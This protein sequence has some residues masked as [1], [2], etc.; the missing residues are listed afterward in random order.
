MLEE[1]SVRSTVLCTHSLVPRTEQ[2]TAKDPKL[3]RK[4]PKNVRIF[5]VVGMVSAVPRLGPRQPK[6]VGWC[7]GALA[8]APLC[9]EVELGSI[10][11][12]QKKDANIGLGPAVKIYSLWT[13]AR[14]RGC[15]GTPAPAVGWT[16][17]TPLR[18]SPG[19][20]LICNWSRREPL[21]EEAPRRGSSSPRLLLKY[22][23]G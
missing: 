8:F 3:V 7:V 2:I 4:L 14:G 12:P 9:L 10:R 11:L 21:I 13:S 22:F 16:L 6:T 5:L 1:W 19:S 17:V 18:P 23:F 20:Q 15:H